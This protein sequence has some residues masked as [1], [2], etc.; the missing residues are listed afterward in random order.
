MAQKRKIV[1]LVGIL[2]SFAVLIASFLLLW[3][4]G[5]FL[6]STFSSL[7]YQLGMSKCHSFTKINGKNFCF[8]SQVSN[9]NLLAGNESL[10]SQLIT[11]HPVTQ[12]TI[13]VTLTTTPQPLYLQLTTEPE[14]IVGSIGVIVKDDNLNIFLH[15]SK[16]IL[17]LPH[18]NSLDSLAQ[19]AS[20]SLVR[21]WFYHTNGGTLDY[22]GAQNYVSNNFGTAQEFLPLR[23]TY[24]P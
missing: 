12:N 16:D 23:I 6:T 10:L 24:T 2:L 3:S 11:D 4:N 15:Y 20:M 7:R 14:T 18:A 13:F 5:N 19:G 17:L 22:A 21:G 9:F 8:S 1:V